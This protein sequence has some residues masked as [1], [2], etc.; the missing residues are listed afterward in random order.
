MVMTDAMAAG[1]QAY[2]D[3]WEE[4]MMSEELDGSG[5]P[6]RLFEAGKMTPGCAYTRSIGDRAAEELGVIAEAELLKKRLKE[7]DQAVMI[8]SDGVWEFLSN[9]AVTD[10]V[11]EFDDPVEAARA[12]VSQA[13]SLWL[14]FEVR[15][16]DIT[17]IIA[18]IDHTAGK[19][20]RAPS[21]QEVKEYEAAEKLGN[22]SGGAGGVEMGENVVTGATDVKPV[23]RGLSA[24]KKKKLGVT[25][26]AEEEEDE[27]EWIMET[28]KKTKAEVERIK[29]ALKGNFMFQNLPETQ[30]KQIYDCMKKTTI[31]AGQV[32]IQQG[33][34]G[35]SFYVLDDGELKVT[36][37]QDD[38][39]IEIMQYKPNPTGANP[40]FGE[41]ALMY[42]KPRAATVT[43][44]TD[45]CL[46]EIDRRSF[47]EILKKSSTKNLMRTLR[48]VEVFKSLSVHQLQRL[49]EKLTE[50]K[51]EPGQ[52]VIRQGEEGS[53]FYIISDGKAII[54]KCNDPVNAP[55]VVM[56]VATIRDG[57]YFGER[58][59]LNS[60]TRA[61]NVIA[62][63]DPA[64]NEKLHVLYISKE[65]FEEVLGPLA[66]IMEDFQREGYKIAVIKQL[67]KR[68]AGLAN[69]KLSDFEIQGLMC[70]A[71]PVKYVLSKF[72]KGRVDPKTGEVT[73]AN[74]PYTLKVRSKS[75]IIEMNMQVR[76]RNEMK[77]L[78]SMLNHKQFV[79]LPLQTLEDDSYIYSI[80][81]TKVSC[82]LS[83]VMDHLE[84]IPEATCRFLAAV[85][86]EAI[87]CVHEECHALGG[88]VYRNLD[89]STITI[90][91]KGWPQL[92][93]M[94]FAVT[95]E[96][97]PR[98]FCGQVHY[99]SPEQ[100][101]GNGHG[102]P[103]DFWQFGMLIYEMLTSSNPWLTGDPVKD[104]E[105]SIYGKITGFKHGDLQFP[106]NTQVSE[107]MAKFV[108]ELL[109]PD[110]EKRLG[111]KKGKLA[112]SSRD[113]IKKH[114]WFEG[115][116]WNELL[117]FKA[118]SPIKGF[119][120]ENLNKL[121]KQHLRQSQ[122]IGIFDEVYVP[123]ELDMDAFLEANETADF[124]FKTRN[125]Q[126][127]AKS[128]GKQQQIQQARAERVEKVKER[129]EKD[130]KIKA[131]G[132]TPPSVQPVAS[133]GGMDF[134]KYEMGLTDM[135][136]NTPKP[137]AV[138]AEAEAR[139]AALFGSLS[140]NLTAATP[141]V[142]VGTESEAQAA[143]DRAKLNADGL[144]AQPAPEETLMQG[145]S[146]RAS[147]AA[148]ELAK[149]L[150]EWVA[151]ST[152]TTTPAPLGSSG[153]TPPGAKKAGTS[154]GFGGFVPKTKQTV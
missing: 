12:V 111:C 29:K 25:L 118:V 37:E 139:K 61:A 6:P 120:E 115:F 41:L 152:P 67:K 13:Y 154:V 142:A 66:K 125:A 85:L 53:T 135:L 43:A 51:Y 32:V 110:V 87:Q 21:E 119:C 86:A 46:W 49:S 18:Y 65:L 149:N 73:K 60:E 131:A 132:G 40:C 82:L 141:T 84:T 91:D 70:S 48:S 77:M 106:E 117:A 140:S 4:Q 54:T 36:I 83:D 109:H 122:A 89:P 34:K 55:D 59:I 9:Q 148:E 38:L 124:K 88:V 52:Y 138:D 27:G 75:A 128:E 95:A 153:W 127:A 7:T 10:T 35:E 22:A 133:T 93:D 50:A 126:T 71:P 146:R 130:E 144:L 45:G 5:D 23:R 44:L 123:S 116:D 137:V 1:D 99:L 64:K 114:K 47:R 105:L 69:A 31:S 39:N 8:A 3:G 103:S 136:S 20:P 98:D 16:D 101:G 90:D 14:Q 107:I 30:S 108:G 63:G 112:S 129:R 150:Q 74:M 145:L 72:T 134:S 121:T 11:F 151:P 2:V 92:L 81:P 15:S 33:D 113:Q 147:K 24:E 78:T 42:S 100:V 97:P 79:P 80:I 19:A 102:L 76:L 68:A 96:P 57:Q 143:A 104:S 94:R 56:Q 58:A 17:L 26:E 62:D 28:H